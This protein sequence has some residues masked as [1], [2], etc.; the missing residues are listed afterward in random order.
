MG[1]VSDSW[2]DRVLLSF[3]SRAQALAMTDVQTPRSFGTP[4]APL[5]CIGVYYIICN[6]GLLRIAYY[7]IIYKIKV[8]W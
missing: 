1:V 4:L 3:S 5:L 8:S 7:F 2:L 6:I